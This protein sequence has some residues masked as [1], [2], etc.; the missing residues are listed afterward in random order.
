MCSS[1]LFR[2]YNGRVV[3]EIAPPAPLMPSVKEYQVLSTTTV[4]APFLPDL[5]GR[6]IGL[7]WDAPLPGA[8]A[9]YRTVARPLSPQELLAATL[10]SRIAYGP[11]P[12]DLERVMAM[13][14]DAYLAEQLAPETI[15]D[16]SEDYT[17][18]PPPQVPPP[19]AKGWQSVAI[20]GVATKHNPDFYIYLT[21]PGEAYLDDVRLVAGTS[22]DGLK[23]NLLKVGNG[24][25][26]KGL[27]PAW[28]VSANLS[29]SAISFLY[30]HGGNTS[31]HVVATKEGST[32]ES[33]IWQ[34]TSGIVS[35]G[36]YTLS[37]WYLTT[38]GLSKPLVRVS[39]GTDDPSTGIKIGRA[40]V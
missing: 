40:H 7:Q 28:T 5:S 18:P 31:L 6:S 4:D 23:P 9:F 1:D 26:E 20:T 10:L 39:G 2:L 19:D 12:D 30:K 21:A 8:R 3:L 17:P 36:L 13:G 33:S 22:D 27:S 37:F 11:T 24:D 32:K 15:P 34:P 14:P 25:F 29:G 35:G 16:N 38:A